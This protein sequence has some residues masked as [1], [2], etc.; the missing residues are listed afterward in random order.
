[1]YNIVDLSKKAAEIILSFPKSDRIRVISHYDA[2]GIAAASI[3][4]KN[5]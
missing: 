5:Y 3:I 4:C 1:M 2:D